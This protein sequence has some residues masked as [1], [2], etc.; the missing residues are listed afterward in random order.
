MD[1]CQFLLLKVVVFAGPTGS[2]L[3]SNTCKVKPIRVSEISFSITCINRVYSSRTSKTRLCRT[4]TPTF[5]TMKTLTL[6]TRLFTYPRQT[7]TTVPS[8]KTFALKLTRGYHPFFQLTKSS[9]RKEITIEPFL[10]KKKMPF[11]RT[12]I[13]T[14]TRKLSLRLLNVEEQ[15]MYVT[16]HLVA[17]K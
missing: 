9:G 4:S 3:Y 16:L 5:R 6:V 11:T 17:L 8:S 2:C 12:T 10:T 1:S 7:I 13:F 15:G 14:V